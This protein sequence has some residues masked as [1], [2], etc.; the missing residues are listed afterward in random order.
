LLSKTATLKSHSLL[1]PLI[2]LVVVV[3]V[4]VVVVPFTT[5][6]KTRV[7]GF[8]TFTVDGVDFHTTFTPN[9]RTRARG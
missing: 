5:F 7:H 8:E 2:I 1:L 3:V 6:T 4:V 9:P